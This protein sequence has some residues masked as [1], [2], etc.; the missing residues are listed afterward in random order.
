MTTTNLIDAPA[1]RV[2]NLS[3]FF[4][5]NNQQVAVLKN[6]NLEVKNYNILGL[7]GPNGAGKT[8]A[9]RIIAGILEPDDGAIFINNKKMLT[10]SNI[11]KKE[12][13]FLSSGTQLYPL[14]TT[15]EIFSLFGSL[16]GMSKIEITHR[17]EELINK[18]DLKNLIKMKIQQMS[19][20]QKQKV[21]IARAL[22]H[23]PSILILDEPTNGLDILATAAVLE[24]ILNLKEEGKA[25]IYSTHI[26]SEIELLTDSIAI[27]YQGN[28]LITSTRDEIIR[29]TESN[30]L[31]QAFL[32]IIKNSPLT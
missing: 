24:F 30:N 25:I 4:I 19:T 10:N 18:L 13:G 26:L 5:Q 31:S 29:H 1:I 17:T 7:L 6:I 12:I 2:T 3:K 22:F 11:L 15:S 20:G 16:Y 9:L 14:Y 8:T 23:N 28:I 32:K 27:I 21:N